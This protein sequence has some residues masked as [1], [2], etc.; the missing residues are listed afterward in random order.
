MEMSSSP[1]TDSDDNA[2]S[3]IL[4]IS[5]ADGTPSETRGNVEP[6]ALASTSSE[7][8]TS[9]AP[10]T[11]T[12]TRKRG[13]YAGL[14][15]EQKVK[16]IRMVH[17]GRKQIDVAN[18]LKISRQTLSSIMKQK[19]KI[20]AASEKPHS[21]CQKR[22]REGA[23]PKLEEAL[24]LWIR[25]AVNK[26]VP[27]SGDLL[28][29]KAEALAIRLGVDDFKFSDG[30]MR[31]FKK[32]HGLSFKKI[33]GESGAVDTTVVVAYRKDRLDELLRAYKP[34]DVFNCDETGL[35][36]K[37]LPDRTLT[38]AGEQ[39]SGGKHSKDRVTVLVGANMS[40]SE[41]LPLL[42]IGRRNEDRLFKGVKTRPVWYKMNKKAWMTR[43]LFEDYIKR[44]DRK[45]EREQ[46]RVI[47]FVD[48]CAAHGAIDN[49][50]AIRLEF[51]PPNTTSVLQP[52][53][54]GI[55][56]NLKVHYRS[57]LLSRVVL[58]HEQ[59]TKY[60]ADL[61]PA[62]YILADA[63]KAVKESAIANS[64]RHA[65]FCALSAISG[66]ESSDTCA[67]GDDSSVDG[68]ALVEDLRGSGMAIPASISFDDYAEVDRC[69][70]FC[71]EFTDDEIVAEVLNLPADGS[72]DDEDDDENVGEPPST[73][74][75]LAAIDTL[76]RV[77]SDSVTLSEMQRDVLT[78]ARAARQTHIDTF[79][80]PV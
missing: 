8:S 34:D 77:Y 50:R 38:F 23:H 67:R 37:L 61:L 78:R 47:I 75:I 12:A 27:V 79:F 9:S 49:L 3:G 14:T 29:Q 62:L 40:G 72:D 25:G 71:A 57:R 56:K 74:Q 41:K 73:A 6:A 35:F 32:R 15:L 54:Q 39:C 51:L 68:A 30:W 11:G 45:F 65:G 80:R 55:I 70:E 58:C 2:I 4:D 22:V 53:D 63:W 20:L 1:S 64:F 10:E 17:G 21:K 48:N 76:G 28:K 5:D 13:K 36:Y 26:K 19:T 42:V 60:K 7:P 43:V 18:E 59:G 52:M 69:T 66:D 33:C 31:G 46:R 16:A 44:L 24:V